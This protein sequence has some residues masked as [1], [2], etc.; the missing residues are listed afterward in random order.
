MVVVVVIQF[1]QLE[2]GQPAEVVHELVSV[3]LARESKEA[4][5]VLE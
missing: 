4:W 5:E 1:V 2:L 3:L